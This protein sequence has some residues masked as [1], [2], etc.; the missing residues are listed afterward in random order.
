VTDAQA[1]DFCHQVE[2][3]L[4]GAAPILIDLAERA[5]VDTRLTPEDRTTEIT[6]GDLPRLGG[7]DGPD[8]GAV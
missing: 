7:L 4:R 1:G 6:V 2:T 3:V 8:G 5:G